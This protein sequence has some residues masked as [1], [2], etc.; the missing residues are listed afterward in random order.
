MKARS[1]YIES[2]YDEI[3]VDWI[4]EHFWIVDTRGN[5]T[6]E[7]RFIEPQVVGL[8]KAL[9]Q[10]VKEAAERPTGSVCA[11]RLSEAIVKFGPSDGAGDGGKGTE[12]NLIM[13]DPAEYAK[14][15]IEER[16]PGQNFLQG[17]G[18]WCVDGPDIQRLRI[19]REVPI[20]EIAWVAERTGKTVKK[21]EEEIL[22]AAAKAIG[23][24]IIDVTHQTSASGIGGYSSA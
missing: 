9:Y 21:I 10:A 22:V 13:D 20:K 5:N 14:P 23:K 15:I 6:V 19:S 1:T 7:T 4:G 16:L 2:K 18:E 24:A 3:R 17:I 11:W 12:M 8:A